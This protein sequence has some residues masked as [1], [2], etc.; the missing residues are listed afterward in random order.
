MPAALMLHETDP[1]QALTD[2]IGPVDDIELFHGQVLVAVYIAPEKTAGG[3]IRPGTN[4][5]EDRHQSKIGLI[6]KMGPNA[7]RP[8]AKWSWPD[9]VE[10]G[11]WVFF[12]V[13]DGWNVTVNGSR[14]NLC[15]ILEDVDVKGRISHP[16]QVW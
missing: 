14:D 6:L 11:D 4:I 2:K 7:F 1:K 12:R 3:I 9:D 5:D 15:R 13:S 16:D 10:V 8:D